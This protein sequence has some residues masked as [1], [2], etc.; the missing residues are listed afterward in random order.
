[1]SV[2]SRQPDKPPSDNIAPDTSAPATPAEPA[3]ERW[4]RSLR[5]TVESIAIAFALAFLF[6]TFEAEAFVIPTGSMAPTLM[7]RHKDVECPQCG[8]HYTASGSEEADRNGNVLRTPQGQIDQTHQVV[9]CTCPICRA[10]MS[11]DPLKVHEA[12]KATHPSYSGDRIWVSKVPYQFA[13][14]KRWDVI[15]FRCPME[16]ETYFIKRLVGLPNETLEIRHGEILSKAAAAR[17]YALAR[18]PADKV[19]AMAQVVHDADYVSPVL[20]QAGWASRWRPW[21]ADDAQSKWQVDADTRS[22]STAGQAPGEAWIR[23]EHR[24]PT[25][26]FWRDNAEGRPAPSNPPRPQLITDFYAFNTRVLRRDEHYGPAPSTLG[27]HWVGDLL[28]DC[29]VDVRGPSGAVLFDLVKGGRHFRATIDVAT[30]R[31]QL[32][33]DGLADWRPTADTP[34][35]GSG[36][37]DVTFA[38]V[39]RQL[40]LWV[41][42]KLVTF[43][44]PTEYPDLHNDEPQSTSD[45]PGDLAPVGI[46]S[47]GAAVAARHVRVLRDIYYIADR[48]IDQ[49]MPITD[50]RARSSMVPILRS[51]E[52]VDFL[53]S[54]RQWKL[55]DGHSAFDDRQSIT[56]DLG[57][58]QFFVL[59]DNSPASAD[60][61]FWSG[62]NYVDRS[63][64]VGK[65][66]FIYWPHAISLPLPLVNVSLPVIPNL[67][68]MGLIR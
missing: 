54:P 13:E 52:L 42:S 7:G 53:A 40:L 57:P 59:G 6:K 28:V 46:G 55:R 35:R 32:S 26:R 31:A 5:D 63:L 25:E 58:D 56:F 50:F 47:R 22:F 24:V 37:Y 48:S 60:A 16:A 62:E 2:A 30:G 20:A 23:Y 43:D 15:V 51:D 27:L 45:D 14:P 3:T 36:T 19:L 39:D 44:V 9:E 10:P 67:P 49:H 21:S 4:G 38:N 11:V 17:E 41:D 65:A 1:M 29:E 33:I 18:K 66:L 61:R 64:L 8:Y 34:L 12:G 68:E